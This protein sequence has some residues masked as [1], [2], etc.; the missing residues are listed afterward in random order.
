MREE[1]RQTSDRRRFSGSRRRVSGWTL[2]S[3]SM[4]PAR[5]RVR[6]R[7]VVGEAEVLAARGRQVDEHDLLAAL[8]AG[9]CWSGGAIW[10]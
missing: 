8:G 5:K 9:V 1:T 4:A 6:G 3:K 10:K 2:P 7:A